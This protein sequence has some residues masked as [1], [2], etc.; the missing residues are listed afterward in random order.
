MRE[1]NVLVCDDEQRIVDDM[2]VMLR[3]SISGKVAGH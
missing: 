1:I 3:G 2:K